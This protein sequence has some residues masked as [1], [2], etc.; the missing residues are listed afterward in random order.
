MF[1]ESVM[2][3]A[4]FIL[5][6]ALT[7]TAFHVLAAAPQKL[8]DRQARH[9]LGRVGFTPTQTEVDRLTGQSANAAVSEL[10]AQAQAS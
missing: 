1:K 5:A 3:P 7:T 4:Q 8:S 2:R 10:I 9:L 6:F